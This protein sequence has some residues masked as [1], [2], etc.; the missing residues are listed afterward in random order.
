[1]HRRFLDSHFHITC[2]PADVCYVEI[3]QEAGEPVLRTADDC[4][5]RELAELMGIFGNDLFDSFS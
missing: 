5:R 4:D 2:N 1:M 3:P